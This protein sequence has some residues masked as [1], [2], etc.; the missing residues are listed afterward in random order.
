VFE[1]LTD[2]EPIVAGPDDLPK[3]SLTAQTA[4]GFVWTF[5]GGI[6]GKV[7]SVLGQIVLAW[8]LDRKAFAFVSMA[9]TVST[10][11]SLV[12]QSGVRDVL[13]Q[14]QLKPAM[15]ENA[16]FWLNLFLGAL[17]SLL[18]IA[19]IPL[20]VLYYKEPRLTGLIWVL[21]GQNLVA[22]IGTIPEVRL[23]VALRFRFLSLL[24][25]ALTGVTVG[26]T[27]LMAWLQCGAYSFV[28]PPLVA[29]ILRTIICW[30]ASGFRVHP[31]LGLSRWRGLFGE[32]WLAVGA[33]FF[34]TV[35]AQGDYIILGGIH[36]ESVVGPYYWAFNLSVQTFQ[37][38]I[39]NAGTVLFPAFSQMTGDHPRQRSAFLRSAQAI[40]GVA[41]PAT[42]LQVVAAD[43]GIR[44]LF[45]PKWYSAIPIVQVLSVGMV[46][47]VVGYPSISLI[48]AQGRFRTLLL[49]SLVWAITFVV[50]VTTVASRSDESHAALA[51]SVAVAA[52][53]CIF[54]PSTVYTA[55][56]SIGGRWRD[57]AWVLTG[58]LAA[59]IAAYA[60]ALGVDRLLAAYSPSGRPF[61]ASRLLADT[62]VFGA[63]Y[64]LALRTFSPSTW[65]QLMIRAEPILARVTR[66][67]RVPA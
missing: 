27:I 51:V 30:A 52:F 31:A 37:M 4:H 24:T 23:V 12:Q 62:I 47:Q 61:L 65:S 36:G 18:T 64:L 14:R 22:A 66:R 15:D 3:S 26:L 58:P 32:S 45:D 56:R 19:A 9:Y 46:L 41:M 6:A 55:I 38:I 57:V 50:A 7:L 10:F 11:A 40:A 13:V 44:L 39:L 49:M 35:V 60:A 17:S 34:F 28:I 33:T 29:L 67:S 63:V 8:V 53:Y 2:A 25:L 1:V 42:V 16:G 48:K 21:A 5:A 20:A 54:G 59:C 43:A